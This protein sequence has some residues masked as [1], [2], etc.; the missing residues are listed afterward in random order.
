M[1]YEVSGIGPRYNGK[2]KKE[3]KDMAVGESGYTVPWAVMLD[4][5]DRAYIRLDYTI[6][7]SPEGTVEMKITR[8]GPGRADYEIDLS[9]TKNFW[10]DIDFEEEPYR[11]TRFDAKQIEAIGSSAYI[12]SLD[13]AVDR[14]IRHKPEYDDDIWTNHDSPDEKDPNYIHNRDYISDDNYSSGAD[15]LAGA[16]KAL[17]ECSLNLDKL[18]NSFRNN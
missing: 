10:S 11:W 5:Q 3:I 4:P 8:I 17:N 2:Q 14:K 13:D 12:C 1:V 15:K 16:R 9:T 18:M 6:E 7:S